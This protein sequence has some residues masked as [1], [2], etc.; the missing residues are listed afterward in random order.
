M[1]KQTFLIP[2][3]DDWRSLNLLLQKINKELMAA[4]KA[5]HILIVNDFSSTLPKFDIKSLK[6]I[7]EIKLI[8]LNK[9]LGSQKSIAI[10][11]KYLKEKNESEIITI[12]DSDGE[13]D[14]Q[15]I[16]EM[17]TLA[18]IDHNYVITSNRTNRK[19]NLLFKFFYILHKV[20]TFLFTS[21]WIS[22]GNFSSFHS[23]NLSEILKENSVWLAYS[24]SVSL[25]CKIKRKYAKRRERYFGES[26]VNFLNLVLHS[27]RVISVLYLRVMFFSMF[28]ILIC[29]NLFYVFKNYIF[30][31]ITLF[32][33]LLNL[34]IQ[35]IRYKNNINELN[36]WKIFIQEVNLV[37][38]Y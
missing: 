8:N 7:E 23:K 30:L 1:T 13:D 26:K 3:Y 18:E 25:N 10:G 14:P 2:V 29:I 11:L 27:F 32:I 6:N 33:I 35:I 28:Y 37:N 22:F 24:S 15:K 38:Q 5:G 20:L 12:M 16:N 31:F 19:E 34:I 36:N 17:T 21:H 4:S 9:N